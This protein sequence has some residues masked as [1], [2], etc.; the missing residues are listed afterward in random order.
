MNWRGTKLR[1]SIKMQLIISFFA[2]MLPVVAFLVAN[3]LYAKNVVRDKVS[4]TYRN[5]LDIFVG[6]TDRQLKEIN[7]YLY[8]MSVADPDVGL[9]MSYPYGS[10]N[11]VLTK[12]R[13]QNKLMRDIGFYNLIDTV[14]LFHESDLILST[15]GQYDDTRQVLRNNIAAIIGQENRFATNRWLLWKD[16]LMPGNDFLIRITEV[17]EGLYVGAIIKISGILDTL[18]VLWDADEIGE[19]GIYRLDGMRLA[20]SLSGKK[21]TIP[22]T[23][24]VLDKQAAYQTVT[25]ESNKQR[26]MVMNRA[27][28][29]AD[30][31]VNIIIP[32]K[33]M[34]KGLPYFQKA[35]YFI[36]AGLIAIF[37]LYL[38][39]IR[40]T[41]FK[42]LQQLIGGMKKISHGMLDVRLKANDT[43]EFLFLAATFNSMAE[44]IKSLKIGMYEE[45]LR[46]QKIELK[47]LQA[48][49]NPH[50]YMN[51]LNIIYN[52]A[53]LKDNDSIKKMALH[54]ADYFRFIMRANR[55]LIS[56]EEELKHIGNYIEIQQFRFPNKLEYVFD[57]PD[58]IRQL[59]LPALLL[60]PFV[61]NAIIHGFVNRRKLFRILVTGSIITDGNKQY[62]SLAVEDNG[63]GYPGDILER[64]NANEPLPQADSSRLGILNVMQRLKLRYGEEADIKFYN[65]AD[66]GGAAVRILLPTAIKNFQEDPDVQSAGG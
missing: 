59:P 5:T 23:D 42:P 24:L 62:L 65:S 19:S 30:M 27:S 56:L 15:S 54:L 39:F 43:A 2:V 53:A 33:D 3:N 40:H 4:Q 22:L 26:Y 45:Q 57:V 37:A 31:A 52:F 1:R 38:F 36:A 49:I 46:A 18:S 34:L 58:S 9:L 35:T 11:Y 50:F 32:E 20:E 16:D 29:M 47:Q 66:A 8:K 48:Q 64:L 60:Q 13:I 41:L 63:A 51:S 61:E 21:Q 44:Q 14:F 25:D 7:D 6:Q 17:T 28:E 12:V 10:D 55:D